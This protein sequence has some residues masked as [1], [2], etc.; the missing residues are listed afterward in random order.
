MVYKSPTVF[1]RR[2]QDEEEKEGD[3]I[4]PQ[5][6]SE[7][8]EQCGRTHY[9]GTASP[10]LSQYYHKTRFI[11]TSFGIRKDEIGSFKLRYFAIT[12]YQY[13]ITL[14]HENTYQGTLSLCE[15]LTEK[16][17]RPL[18]NYQKRQTNIQIYS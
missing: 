2:T 10:H 5:E 15:L 7:E 12:A 14:L 11:D 1:P 16:E 17:G 13:S 9:G 8:I 4:F 6:E 3:Y 18:F